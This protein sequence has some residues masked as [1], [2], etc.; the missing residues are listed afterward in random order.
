MKFCNRNRI[1][2]ELELEL[3]LDSCIWY[4]ICIKFV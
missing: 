1:E 2:L 3:E 4:K